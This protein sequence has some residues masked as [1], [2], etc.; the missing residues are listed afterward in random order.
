[1]CRRSETTPC[2]SYRDVKW[3][4]E[5]MFHIICHQGNANNMIPP[6]TYQNDQKAELQQYILT[7]MGDNRNSHALLGGIQN[8]T[9]TLEDFQQFFCKT[10]HTFTT[11]SSNH[12]P[13][14]LPKGTEN[15]STQKPAHRCLYLHNCQ[16]W[17]QPNM[18]QLS[19][20]IIK[21]WYI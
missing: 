10:K 17:K 13:W 4:H 16:A 21:L 20:W 15:V 2:P 14:Y 7:R 18:L 12:T 6:H 1:M 8:G 5:K 11:Q 19:E 3:A 9:A